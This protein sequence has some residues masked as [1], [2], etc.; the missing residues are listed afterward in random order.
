MVYGLGPLVP[1]CG[2]NV[3]YRSTNSPSWSHET[4]IKVLVPASRWN[5]DWRKTFSPGSGH[6]LGLKVPLCKKLQL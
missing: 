3:D 1:V 2:S 5:R 4:E 6:Q